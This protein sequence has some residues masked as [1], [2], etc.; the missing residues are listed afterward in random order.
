MYGSLNGPPF[1]LTT[2]FTRSGAIPVDV[3]VIVTWQ[4]TVVPVVAKGVQVLGGHVLV[5][6]GD[7]VAAVRQ[8]REGR[9]IVVPA[10]DDVVDH[11]RSGLVGGG[12]EHPEAD[13]GGFVFFRIE[14]GDVRHMDRRLLLDNA[15]GRRRWATRGDWPRHRRARR[16][17]SPV[18]V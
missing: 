8:P 11:L 14:I 12:R 13:P 6:E 9:E 5:V 15:A 3:F 4:V 18:A 10:Q 7:D 17:G 2:P 16:V 1:T